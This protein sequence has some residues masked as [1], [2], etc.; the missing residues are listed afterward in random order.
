M[1][2]AAFLL[3]AALMG[4]ALGQTISSTQFVYKM[5]QRVA[6]DGFFSSYHDFTTTPMGTPIGV[7]AL[8]NFGCGSGK[9]RDE[10]TTTVLDGATYDYLGEVT[11]SGEGN[12]SFKDTS[13]LAYDEKIFKLGKSFGS[14]PVRLLGK[15]ETCIRNYGSG[16]SMDALFDS[17]NVL[18]KD[19]SA[20]LKWRSSEVT[21]DDDDDSSNEYLLDQESAT[22]LNVDAT[23]VGKGHIGALLINGTNSRDQNHN[24]NVQTRID[25]D[26]LGTYSISKKMIHEVNSNP[27]FEEDT[28]WLDCCNG[29]YDAMSYYDQ[30]YLNSSRGIFDCTCYKAQGNAQF[31]EPDAIKAW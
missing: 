23:F 21:S 15:D 28:G 20:R 25:E 9:Y 6:G 1:A 7:L 27:A 24:I 29:G 12:I 18:S 22:M 30:K 3:S 2:I 16:A 5:D 19:L 31:L 11:S 13:D 4:I 10:S 14:G 8:H 26:Y 17:A